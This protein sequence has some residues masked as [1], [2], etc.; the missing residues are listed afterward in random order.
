MQVVCMISIHA[1]VHNGEGMVDHDLETRV[2][3][4]YL[5]VPPV[6]G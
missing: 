2:L 3:L 4:S 1:L 5:S 6:F